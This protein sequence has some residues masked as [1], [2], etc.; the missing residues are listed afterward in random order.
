VLKEKP[1][2]KEELHRRVLEIVDVERLEGPE[3]CDAYIRSSLLVRYDNPGLMVD[4][5][6]QAMDLASFLDAQTY[7]VKVVA[8][9][10][11]RA[12]IELGNAYRVADK[13]D[14]ASSALG[15]ATVYWSEGSRDELLKAHMFDYQATLYAARRHF[16]EASEA[17]DTVHSIYMGTG[18]T[19]RAGRALISNGIYCGYAGDYEQAIRLLKDGLEKVDHA[20]DPG[21]AA[22]AVQSQVSF[23][24][25]LDRFLD[26]RQL[27]QSYRFP[28]D[29][30][31]ARTNQLK[32]RWVEAAI[33][34]GLGDLQQAEEG[35]LEVMRGFGEK[36]LFY[37]GALAGLDLVHLWYRQGRREEVREVVGELLKV[38]L[39]YRINREA[40]LALN[41][42][43]S[44]LEQGIEAGAIL[45]RVTE[46]IRRA[47]TQP[48]MKYDD[49]FS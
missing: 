9:C 25:M 19:H 34:A 29:V 48:G 26:A 42:L 30:L 44:A 35:L 13:L 43:E 41:L 27:L 49:W 37:K 7:G 20:K 47:E 5:A 8:D 14:E 4:L 31:G 11:C 24:V 46:F 3:L 15:D 36:E 18:D 16:I 17:L 40:L 1:P 32:I 38:F 28:A 12:S 2:T 22:A 33:Q 23:L 10:R 39:T 45:N 21:L 6:K